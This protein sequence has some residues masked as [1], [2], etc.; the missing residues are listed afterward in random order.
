MEFKNIIQYY[1]DAEKCTTKI[2]SENIHQ[3]QILSLNV[4]FLL[5]QIECTFN[6][7]NSNN[8]SI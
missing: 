7:N 3:T 1:I 4:C 5:Y 8:K 6:D 2:N